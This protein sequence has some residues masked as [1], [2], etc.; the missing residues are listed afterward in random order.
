MEFPSRRIV[1]YDIRGLYS[2]CQMGNS[3]RIVYVGVTL[4]CTGI[5]EDGVGRRLLEF[6]KCVSFG[7]MSILV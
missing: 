2:G 4:G 3:V 6:A 5:S 1:R 7:Y